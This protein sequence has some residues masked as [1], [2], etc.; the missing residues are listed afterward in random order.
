MI[1]KIHSTTIGVADQDKALDFYVNTLGWEKALDNMIGAEDRFLSV[2]PPG[3][4]TQLVLA[5]LRWFGENYSK[6]T[7]ISFTTRDIDATYKTLSERGVTFE[8]PVQDMP[9]GQKATWFYDLDGNKF[10]IVEE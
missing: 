4:Q 7:G 10:F 5:P 2:V 9:W 6:E 8:G 1:S 3:A